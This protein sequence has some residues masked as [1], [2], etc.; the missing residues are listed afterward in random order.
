MY[1]DWRHV[2]VGSMM[3][4]I[5]ACASEQR[6]RLTA[7]DPHAGDAAY[8]EVRGTIISLRVPTST[9][10][11]SQD[12]HSANIPVADLVKYDA[13]TKF[14]LDGNAATLDQIQQYMN[15]TVN[16]HMR[17]G[18]FFAETANFSSILPLNVKPAAQSAQAASGGGAAN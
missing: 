9:M 10:I 6:A 18:Q 12:D 13:Q 16:G 4:V 7:P 1:I 3:G 15:V 11:I 17:A 8:R 5:V 14:L 2:V